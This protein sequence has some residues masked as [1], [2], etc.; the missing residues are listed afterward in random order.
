MSRTKSLFTGAVVAVSV[1]YKFTEH[2]A[3]MKPIV[4]WLNGKIGG[5]TLIEILLGALVIYLLVSQGEKEAPLTEPSQAQPPSQ[6]PVQTV[7]PTISPIIDASQHHHHYAEPALNATQV[8]TAPPRRRILNIVGKK[9]RIAWLD[10]AGNG[11]YEPEDNGK[12]KAVVAEFRN[13]PA[14]FSIITWRHVRAS[15]AFYNE[16]GA[17]IGD[18]GRALWLDANSTIVDMPSNITRTIIVAILVD[19][20][21]A[22]DGQD[23]RPL[24][25]DIRRAK[26]VLQDDRE[27]STAFDVIVDLSLGAVGTTISVSPK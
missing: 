25:Q 21:F 2:M 22:F 19:K 8:L 17:E 1:I 26:I 18:V 4:T 10:D 20:W 5:D 16:H 14:E 11:L 7:N 3:Y 23:T 24:S 6:S 15:I 27:F 13:E 9:A 12:F